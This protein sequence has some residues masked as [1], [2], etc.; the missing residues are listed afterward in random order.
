MNEQR[1]ANTIKRYLNL[2]VGHLNQPITARLQQA[3]AQALARYTERKPALE[4]AW[5][6]PGRSAVGHGGHQLW[7]RWWIAFVLLFV[8][9]LG[10]TYWQYTE[11]NSDTGEIDAAL[12]ADEL[13]VGAYLDNRLDAWLKR[14]D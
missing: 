7:T 14:S 13:P 8:A 5:A 6:G 2:S 9:A 12:L 1:V 3:R 10:I 4:F 11:Q